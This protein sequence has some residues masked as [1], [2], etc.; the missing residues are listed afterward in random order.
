MPGVNDA[1]CHPTQTAASFLSGQPTAEDL[2]KMFNKISIS[3]LVY[4][5]P[6]PFFIASMY[7]NSSP[8]TGNG[9]VQEQPRPPRL[10]A[11]CN[12]CHNAKV[13]LAGS[14]SGKTSA[15][16]HLM[17]RFDA[18]GSETAAPAAGTSTTSTLA[19]TAFPGSAGLLPG[20]NEP[21]LRK[22]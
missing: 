19:S 1:L 12:P 21:D 3:N 11:A 15:N 17:V 6:L 20:T 13:S 4:K 5:H 9:S 2:Q 7:P 8:A 22:K 10:R 14:P 16:F 18:V